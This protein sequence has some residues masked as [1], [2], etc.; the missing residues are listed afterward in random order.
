VVEDVIDVEVVSLFLALLAVAA[1]VAVAGTVLLALVGRPLLAR[2]RRDLR[3]LGIPF[4]LVVTAVATSG[5]LYFS[6][7]AGFPPCVLC[8]W[9]R[10]FMY[11]LVPILLV[12]WWKPAW[13]L[14][15]LAL[16]MAAV[17]AAIATY[18]VAI[19]RWPSLEVTSCAVDNPCTIRWVEE[20][21]YLTIPVMS[22]SAF[23]LIGTLLLLDTFRRSS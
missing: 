5:S 23:L 2:L 22:L 9:Q 1:Q 14:Q 15:H 11:P 16:G 4:A 19:E 21:G 17:G 8:W 7:G 3:G 6:E 13:R 18:H 12:A 10:G 20:L